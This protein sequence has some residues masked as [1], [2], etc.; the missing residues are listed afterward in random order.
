MARSHGVSR[1]GGVNIIAVM[2]V[3]LAVALPLF[4][5]L[6]R[7]FWIDGSFTLDSISRILGSSRTWRILA[8]TVGQALASSALTLAVGLPVAW[9]LARYSFPGRKLVR[10]A[11]MVPFVLPSVVIGVAF[12]TILGPRGF[13]DLRG[14]WWAI[15]AAHVCFN[16]AVVLRVV[17]SAFS[18]VDSSLEESAVLLGASRLRRL[19]HITMPSVAPAI[20]SAAVIIFLYSLT[21]FGVIVLLGGGSVTTIEVEIWT[22][23]TRQFDLSGAAVL[24]G[25][26]ALTVVI[27][28]SF[29]SP[30][31]RSRSARSVLARAHPPRTWKQKAAVAAAILVVFMIS[32]LPLL[33]IVE[34][35]LLV[36][37]GYSL[38]HWRSVGSAT[39]GTGLR[40]SPTASILASLRAAIPASLL[41][42]ALGIPAARA[43][44]HKPNGLGSRVLLLPLAI[45]A[46][47]VGLGLLLLST[48]GPVDLRRSSILVVLAQTLVALPVVVRSVAPAI[49]SLPPALGEAAEIAGASAG[50][51]W[52]RIEFPLIR[53]AVMAAA[54][55]AVVIALGEFGATVFV[56]RLGEPTMPVAIE[57]LMSR[58]GQ[59]GMGQAMVLACLLALVCSV[60]IWVIDWAAG[61]SSGVSLGE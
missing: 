11:A 31:G 50:R 34:R 60:I 24:A 48:R 25:V 45:S 42:L 15:L 6:V 55:L 56:A 47:T 41:A 1:T 4:A 22:R 38:A 53:A 44:A 23:A 5:V 13:V 54:G 33:A 21:S 19:R 20:H 39:E 12:A 14:T 40:I 27:V 18:S 2:V 9:I 46:T 17:G 7:S 29:R 61:S 30:V 8:L 32:V 37:D 10:T 59:A 35:S 28:L 43:V 58:P 49:R 36:G 16:L 3:V 57:R 51:I 52:R 26:Q